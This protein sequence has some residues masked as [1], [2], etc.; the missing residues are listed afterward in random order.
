MVRIRKA[1]TETDVCVLLHFHCNYRIMRLVGHTEEGSSILNYTR[2]SY[3]YILDRSKPVSITMGGV[4]ADL[5]S[6][7]LSGNTNT[8]TF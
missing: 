2:S 5:L 3:T 1:R 6:L 7:L 4:G 8:Y